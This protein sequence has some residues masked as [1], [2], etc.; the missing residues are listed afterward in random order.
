MK[1]IISV[2]L[3]LSM[4][5][6]MFVIPVD[7]YASQTKETVKVNVDGTEYDVKVLN[8]DYDNNMYIS[9]NDMALALKDTKRAYEVEWTS[10]DG[11]TC[12]VLKEGSTTKE[13]DADKEASDTDSEK[14]E[15]DENDDNKVN[16]TRKRFLINIGG[17]DYSF[18]MI[19]VSD[20]DSKDCYVNLGEFALATNMD[21]SCYDNKVYINS[22]GQFD[23][24]KY[25][26]LG[27]G[28]PYMADSCLVGDATTGT[29]YY[30]ENADEVVAI[31]STTKLMTYLIIREAI[32]DGR[33]SESDMVTF[34]EEASEIS[35][36]SNGVIR[37]EPGQ[38]AY[39]TDAIKG[40]LICSSNE[41]SLALAEKLCTSE[42]AFVELMNQK[43]VSIGLSGDVRFYNP[44][45]LPIYEDDVLT[46][47]KQNHLTANDMFKLSSYILDKHPEI[48]DITSIKKTKLESL[49]NFE[50]VNTNILLYNVPGC[51]GLKTGTT[52]KAQSCLVSAYETED[53]AG[54][55]HYIVTIVYGAENNQ[56]QS[57]TSLVLMRYGIQRYNTLTLGLVPDSGKPQEIPEDLEGLIGAV[58]NTARRNAK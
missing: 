23:F 8:H 19:P 35:K 44:H 29:I 26:L 56:M 45:G 38:T 18:Y 25:D 34:S 57:Y 17:N 10:K 42:E 41:C 53:G 46:T 14:T 43:A 55:T 47:K 30:S 4:I 7:S 2:F 20:K 33:L 49:N 1:K 39:I 21:V 9:L 24:N 3:I 50:A 11:Q 12:I 15:S 36:S 5:L 31:A 58:V 6:M 51:V 40:M 22:K 16:F 37:V 48:T 27:S 28:I 52:D 54:N 32:Q 13:D